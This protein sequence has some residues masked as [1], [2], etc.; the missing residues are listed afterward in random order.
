MASIVRNV[1]NWS[2]QHSHVRQPPG[3]QQNMCEV[4]GKNP[5]FVEKGHKH[6]YCGRTCA[7]ASSATA[8][9]SS[10]PLLAS[11]KRRVAAASTTSPS[12]QSSSSNSPSSGSGYGSTTSVSSSS[13]GKTASAKTAQSCQMPSSDC[14]F[15]GCGYEVEYFGYCGPDHA[16][17][18]VKLGHA[19]ACDVCREQP[20][21]CASPGVNSGIGF[22]TRGGA[23]GGKNKGTKLCPGC[24]RVAKGGT[25]IK[26]I[27]SRDGKFQQVRKQF[28]KEWNVRQESL[29]AVDKVYQIIPPREQLSRYQSYRR[30]LKN[31]HEIRTYHAS[32]VICDLGTKGPFLC[33]R[34][35][36]GVCTVARS[37]FNQFAFEEPFNQG[38]FGPGIY[39][40]INPKLADKYATT[41]TTSPYRVIVV[42]DVLLDGQQEVPADESIFVQSSDAINAAY[43]IMYS[44]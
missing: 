12:P 44:M 11:V 34:K 29:P 5:K 37:S 4:C 10:G 13:T 38:R 30:T 2:S 31:P 42:C 23:G 27:A 40:Y 24:E 32:L 28:I 14:A 35:G 36:C 43:V 21:V 3:P 20:G 6:P 19:E 25:Q 41:V 15:P 16:M 7:A 18:A 17:E 39:T 26:E 1:V 22:G 9:P 33:E 8:K